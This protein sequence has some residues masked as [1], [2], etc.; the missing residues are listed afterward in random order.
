MSFTLGIPDDLEPARLVERCRL[1][2]RVFDQQGL[3]AQFNAC[4]K[5]V[6]FV[7]S[8]TDRNQEL[9]DLP[10]ASSVDAKHI[11]Q[12]A[13]GPLIKGTHEPYARLN[14]HDTA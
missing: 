6:F 4:L 7:C 1:L 12:V 2:A 10:A 9:A 13:A 5:P 11:P 14:S 3:T 8:F